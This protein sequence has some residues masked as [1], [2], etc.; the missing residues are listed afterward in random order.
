MVLNAQYSSPV[1]PA[2]V[3]IA[4]FPVGPRPAATPP[5]GLPPPRRPVARLLDLVVAGVALVLLSPVMAGIA[6]LVALTSRGPVLFRQVRLGQHCRPFVM[7][8]FR[9]MHVDCDDGPHREYVRALLA[10]P[11]VAPEGAGGLFKLVDDPRITRLGRWLR[12]TSLDELPQLVN[13]LRGDMALVGP[14]PVLP[15][16]AALFDPRHAG[17]FAV[18]PGITGL[19]QTSGRNRLTMTEALDLDVEYVRRRSL[20]LDLAILLRTIPVVLTHEGVG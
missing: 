20:R 4:P 17:R 15:W 10:D 8:K 1:R 13:V 12:T 18:P 16:E 9:T 14:R 3:H 11:A 6:A 19:W 7:L 5:A 2:T